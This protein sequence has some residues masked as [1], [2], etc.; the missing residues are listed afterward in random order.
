MY[1]LIIMQ[2]SQLTFCILQ[3]RGLIEEIRL[4]FYMKKICRVA[5]AVGSSLSFDVCHTIILDLC[6]PECHDLCS[7]FLV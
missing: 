1:C 4:V 6:C 3:M 7:C 2:M 5:L